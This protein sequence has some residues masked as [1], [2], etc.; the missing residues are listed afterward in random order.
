[1]IKKPSAVAD[2]FFYCLFYHFAS[3]SESF[4]IFLNEIALI[5]TAEMAVTEGQM[6]Y[7]STYVRYLA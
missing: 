7:N 5:A 4:F 3:V 6:L 1:M 2:G